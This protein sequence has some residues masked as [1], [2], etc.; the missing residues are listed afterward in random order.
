MVTY[1]LAPGEVAPWDGR[2][3]LVTHYGER[4]DRMVSIKR[5]ERL[6]LVEV[7]ADSEL[8]FVRE[9]E[10]GEAINAA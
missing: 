3:R 7:E 5:G 9:D 1:R 10:L 4:M 8:W 6:P 2:Y